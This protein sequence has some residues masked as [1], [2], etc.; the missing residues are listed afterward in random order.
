MVDVYV[1]DI[2]VINRCVP[3]LRPGSIRLPPLRGGTVAFQ[4]VQ[5]HR[6]SP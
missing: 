6:L 4:E 1:D 2:L 3:E 5:Y